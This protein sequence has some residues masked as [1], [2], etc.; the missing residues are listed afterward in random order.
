MTDDVKRQTFAS[1]WDAIEDSPSEAANMRRRSELTIALR[2]VET[3]EFFSRRA[4]GRTGEGLGRILDKVPD[5][6]P[7]QGDELPEGWVPE[8]LDGR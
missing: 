2:E 7:E 1:V 6:S 3:T 8:A 5:R 4:A